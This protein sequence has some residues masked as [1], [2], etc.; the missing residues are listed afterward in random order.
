MISVK[1]CEDLVFMPRVCHYIEAESYES[2][3]YCNWVY[4]NRS[5]IN[6]GYIS[7]SWG[8]DRMAACDGG[9]NRQEPHSHVLDSYDHVDLPAIS[10]FSDN[11][12]KTTELLLN[13]IA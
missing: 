3:Y 12:P 6:I 8:I 11:K 13:R 7:S 1:F 4:F 2:I 5:D 10:L 9:K